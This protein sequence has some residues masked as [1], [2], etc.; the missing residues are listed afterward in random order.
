MKKLGIT[1]II[2]GLGGFLLPFC[3]LQFKLVTAAEKSLGPLGLFAPLIILVV[4]IALLIGAESIN[5]VSRADGESTQYRA[6]LAR[7]EKAPEQPQ[8]LPSRQ[9]ILDAG[10]KKLMPD[11]V[12][13]LYP[14][15]SHIVR[16]EAAGEL[17]MHISAYYAGKAGVSED[18][19]QYYL[20]AL[21]LI[22]RDEAKRSSPTTPPSP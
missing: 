9:E 14:F 19:V 2:I 11:V 4:G 12:D 1:F 13:S 18:D 6:R 5:L 22:K 16:A 3:G 8:F 7:L 17:Y 20:W 15:T 21:N 10:V